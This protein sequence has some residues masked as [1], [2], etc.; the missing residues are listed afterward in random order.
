MLPVILF[1]VGFALSMTGCNAPLPAPSGSGLPS[2]ENGDDGRV[3]DADG[4]AESVDADASDTGT[5]DDDAVT[6][7]ADATRLAT[8]SFVPSRYYASDG[9]RGGFSRDKFFLAPESGEPTEQS[10][11]LAGNQVVSPTWMGP[12]TSE[13]HI[14]TWKDGFAAVDRTTGDVGD[15]I[16]AEQVL[17]GGESTLTDIAFASMVDGHLCFAGNDNGTG[18]IMCAETAWPQTSWVN[19][20]VVCIADIQG[21]PQSIAESGGKL[22][23]LV[24]DKVGVMEASYD[25]ICDSAAAL[26]PS[27]SL[28]GQPIGQLLPVEGGKVAVALERDVALIDGAGQVTKV[29]TGAIIIDAAADADG[30]V[31]YALHEDEIA[32]VDVAGRSVTLCATGVA[33][34]TLVG[35]DASV[36]AGQEIYQTKCAQ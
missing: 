9:M 36:V 35:E 18:V 19:Q 23:V 7:D 16:R 15:I 20:D 1:V 34:A 14:L 29:P 28:G 5:T 24:G 30:S 26:V 17:D 3:D 8:L 22:F 31:V 27:I 2:D 32:V 6:P 13:Y 11:P 25:A 4:D 10:M 12:V 21:L 33:Y